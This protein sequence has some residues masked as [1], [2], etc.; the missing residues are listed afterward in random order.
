MARNCAHRPSRF[1]FLPYYTE[2]ALGN[3]TSGVDIGMVGYLVHCCSLIPHGCRRWQHCCCWEQGRPS[4]C[5]NE[6]ERSKWTL[7]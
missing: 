4:R 5:N 1:L 6:K 3:T 7:Q 2:W